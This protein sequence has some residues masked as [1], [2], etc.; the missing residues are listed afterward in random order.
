MTDGRVSRILRFV[1]KSPCKR[2]VVKLFMNVTPQAK[3]LQELFPRMKI[4]FNTRSGI[5]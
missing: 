2:I 1:Q 4:F 5:L 3:M